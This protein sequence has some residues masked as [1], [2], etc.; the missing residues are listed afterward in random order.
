MSRIYETHQV[1]LAVVLVGG[2]PA[3]GPVAAHGRE[4]AVGDQAPQH[5]VSADVG[6]LL[7]LVVCVDDVRAQAVGDGGL[8][9]AYGAPRPPLPDLVRHGV[10]LFE[11]AQKVCSEVARN[12]KDDWL[13]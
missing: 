4:A 11:H 1:T 12:T 6:A 10:N 7:K 3:L 2:C 5:D 13:R 9:A 8:E